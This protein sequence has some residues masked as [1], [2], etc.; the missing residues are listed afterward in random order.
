MPFISYLIRRCSAN[1][2]YDV[3]LPYGN[4]ER[5]FIKLAS[6][7]GCLFNGGT[8][9]HGISEIYPDTAPK[10][11]ESTEFAQLGSRFNLQFRDLRDIKNIYTPHFNSSYI[12][13]HIK[14]LPWEFHSGFS[15]K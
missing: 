4:V 13:K 2:F 9:L 8:L 12:P 1:F 15:F 10:W 3:P 14:S 6:G 5:N 11:W 7:D